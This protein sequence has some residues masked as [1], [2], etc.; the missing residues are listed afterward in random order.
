MRDAYA[1]GPRPSNPILDP[2]PITINGQW[3]ICFRWN[4]GDV[5]DIEIVDDH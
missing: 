2:A 5:H 1:L 4:A 3:R